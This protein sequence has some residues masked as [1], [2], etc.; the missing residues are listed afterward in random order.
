LRGIRVEPA[1][2]C[3]TFPQALAAVRSGACAAVLPTMAK[4]E[5]PASRF[6]EL[7][8]PALGDHARPLLLVHER[9]LARVRPDAA[10]ALDRLARSLSES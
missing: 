3:E 4:A 6:H 2:E 10:R 9:R 5:L 7:R 1:I 8:G